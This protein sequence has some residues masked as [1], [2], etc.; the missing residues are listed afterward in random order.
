M[1]L[2]KGYLQYFKY[3]Y[4]YLGYRIFLS[5][6]LSILVGLLDGFG[7]AMFLPLLEMVN[8]NESNAQSGMETQG[9]TFIVSALKYFSFELSL[10]TILGSMLFFFIS[11]GIAKF[12]EGF[13]KVYLQEYFTKRMR[14]QNI[15]LLSDFRYKD[16]V[17][18]DA[19]RIQNTLSGE[20]SK[21]VSSFR[22]F[23][24][25]MQAL[26]ML[27]VYIF[28]A[29]IS[30]PE[31]A[32][33]VTIG[34]VISNFSFRFI[35]KKT[36]NL[37]KK[38]T[39]DSH[40][41]EGLLL[42]L[43]HNFKYL[44]STGLIYKYSKKLQEVINDIELSNRK[45]GLY[46]AILQSVREPMVVLVVVSVIV[47]QVKFFDQNLGLI[48]MSL[49]FFYRALTFVLSLQTEWNKFLNVSGSLSNMKEFQDRL[50]ASSDK[51]KEGESPDFNTKMELSQIC[52]AYG[53]NN[54]LD[55]ISLTIYK[56]ETVAFVGESGSGKSTLLNI[57]STLLMANK[58]SFKIDGVS[59]EGLNS[60]AYQQ[61]IGYITQ[62]PV[63]FN[64]SVFDN[65]TF[66]SEKTEANYEKFELALKQASI[67]D[68]VESLEFKED[69]LLGNNGINLSGGQRQRIS[70][71]RELYK[72]IDILIMD[73]ATSALDSET[74]VDIKSS[75]E[76]FKGHLTI[77]I[78]AHR[79]A[80]IKEADRI[81]LMDKGRIIEVGSFD[82]LIRSSP[83]F[84]KMIALQEL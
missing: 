50:R 61:S 78:V 56:N 58:G 47:V 65:V 34:G 63:V 10:Y 74:E 35:Y 15:E 40:I 79:L 33:L 6:G 37:S 25:S 80:T 18:A 41:Y 21:V 32:F 38:I 59:I 22:T 84:Q 4:L 27:G 19:G 28:L 23:F 73:E 77:L 39:T 12:F 14:F 72:R 54:I 57:I 26:V 44:K 13:Y 75:I 11:K 62:E 67:H 2:N 43:I 17:E 30:N 45:V 53:K 82:Y 81:V 83:K 5:L 31:F 46:G 9:L 70:I 48:V 8:D 64:T 51:L 69:Q 66:W 55:E 7:L 76:A 49:L 29:Y 60:L 36:I 20:T 24:S 3:F 16:F 71:A 42:Q 68:F 52:F 1:G